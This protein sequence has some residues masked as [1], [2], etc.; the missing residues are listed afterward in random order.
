MQKIILPPGIWTRVFADQLVQSRSNLS[1][2]RI[3]YSF[4]DTDP[5]ADTD[6]YFVM[7]EFETKPFPLNKATGAKVYLMPDE[8]IAVE[9][10]ML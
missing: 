2:L 4:E 3:H 5:A 9:V 6:L 7:Q 8:D 10:V 1:G